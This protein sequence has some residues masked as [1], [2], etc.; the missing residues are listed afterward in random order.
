V[1]ASVCESWERSTWVCWVWVDDTI[2]S[3]G[4]LH[5]GGPGT[6]AISTSTSTSSTCTIS[7]G[8]QNSTRIVSVWTD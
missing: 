5:D 8:A 2:W 6:A 7:S 1:L 4:T 3:A